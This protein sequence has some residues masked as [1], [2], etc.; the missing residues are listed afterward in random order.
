MFGWWLW[1]GSSQQ[2]YLSLTQTV[3]TF[4]V[5]S[6]FSPRRI[7]CGIHLLSEIDNVIIVRVSRDPR[8]SIFATMT[9]IKMVRVKKITGMAKSFP[10][11]FSYLCYSNVKDPAVTLICKHSL[12]TRMK[13]LISTNSWSNNWSWCFNDFQP[14]NLRFR[15]PELLVFY[16]GRTLDLLSGHSR[17][18]LRLTLTVSLITK[19]FHSKAEGV[20]DDISRLLSHF[21]AL[22]YLK[23]YSTIK[24]FSLSCLGWAEFQ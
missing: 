14:D 1:N 8:H 15:V 23:I 18:C 5:E 24:H 7:H 11:H 6:S 20:V 13:L 4:I 22:T 21:F 9:P 3:F 16:C 17:F 2:L 10:I 19:E 12:Q